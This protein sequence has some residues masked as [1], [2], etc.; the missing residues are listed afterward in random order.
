[1][2][3]YFPWDCTECCYESSFQAYNKQ[4]HSC[5]AFTFL[6]CTSPT[7][8]GSNLYKMHTAANRKDLGNI[9][10]SVRELSNKNKLKIISYKL[11]HTFMITYLTSANN[12]SVSLKYL[13]DYGSIFRTTKG[14]I[15]TVLCMQQVFNWCGSFICQHEGCATNWMCNIVVN[16]TSHWTAVIIILG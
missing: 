8:L 16:S 6:M 4:W 3:Y 11:S 10:S 9:P 14:G 13:I 15:C 1:M 7:F 5:V 12:D 2:N